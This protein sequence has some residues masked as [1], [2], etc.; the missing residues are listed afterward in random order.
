MGQLWQ[1]FRKWIDGDEAEHHLENMMADA[2]PGSPS[3]QFIVRVVDKI[4]ADLVSG[5]YIPSTDNSPAYFPPIYS[6]FLSE[7]DMKNWS[8][9]RLEHFQSRVA[10]GVMKKINELDKR[11]TTQTVRIEVKPD[12]TLN[13]G[14]IRVQSLS[15]TTKTQGEGTS[16]ELPTVHDTTSRPVL[17]KLEIH[18]NGDLKETHEVSQKEIY[19]GRGDKAKIKLTGDDRIG[20]I[21]ASLIFDGSG[22]SVMSMN[23]NPT[24]IQ[25]E[26][27]ERRERR[28]LSDGDPI[29]I[30]HFKLI[31]RL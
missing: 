25:G 29:D 18:E 31:P 10:E 30:Y 27:L 21:H 22:L 12:G 23:D 20:R 16:G 26:F 4:R 14:Q 9:E 7:S 19:V 6:V 3:M 1:R 15:E 17:Y 11:K 13:P 8:G 28:T 24:S 2:K 5:T